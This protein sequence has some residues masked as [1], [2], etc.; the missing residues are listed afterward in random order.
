MGI[1]ME[2]IVTYFGNHYL[3]LCSLLHVSI[4]LLWHLSP[5]QPYSCQRN[6]SRVV[7][8]LADAQGTFWRGQGL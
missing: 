7:E 2:K 4:L 6:S 5:M 1:L 8:T 3:N